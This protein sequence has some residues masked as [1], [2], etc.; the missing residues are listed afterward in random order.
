MR[1]RARRV[2]YGLEDIAYL[3]GRA[4]RSTGRGARRLWLR[5]SLENRRRIAVGL[6]VVLA[7]VGLRYA[8]VPILPCE[9]PGGDECPPEDEAAG[10]V[11][12]DPLAYAHVNLDPGTEQAEAAGELAGKLPAL[13]AQAISRL[14][15]PGVSA[16]ELDRRLLP[17][18]G[19][20]AALAVVPGAEGA[21]ERVTLL[22]AEDEDAALRYAEA[23]LG[24]RVET[25][26]RDGVELRVDAAGRAAAL[27]DGFL[28]VGEEEAVG[29]V[30]EVTEGAESLSDS[31]EAGE[32]RDELPSERLADAYVS[33]DGIA[34]LLSRDRGVLGSLDVLVNFAASRGV[35]AALVAEDDALELTVESRLDPE[36]LE[37]EPGFFGALPPF[38]PDL[39]SEASPEA[40]AYVG[41]GDPG[42]SI[43]RLLEQAAVEAPALAAGFEA[44]AR[45]VRRSGGLDLEGDV[46]PLL[47]S[48]ASFTLEPPPPEAAREDGERRG[49]GAEREAGGGL[50]E[51]VP[52]APLPPGPAAPPFLTFL[53]DD[54]E[55]EDARRALARLQVPIARAVKPEEGLQAPVYRE[56][57][58]DGVE[59]RSVRVSPAVDLTFAVFDG[60]LVVST[61]PAGVEQVKSGDDGLDSSD[62]FEAATEDF[63][64]RVSLLVYLDLAGLVELAEAAG[65]AE[66]PA[67]SLVAGDL[68]RLDLAGIAIKQDEGALAT[69]ARV[70]VD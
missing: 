64:V 28:V 33:E 37:A 10:L 23:A 44:L 41:L 8:V 62:P 67:Y 13:A 35:A 66:D 30:I 14:E 22:E 6:V 58:I 34:E 32:V 48:E 9:F 61:S 40:L 12:A 51:D 70:T 20:E 26:E 38:D 53:A 60:K 57:E 36:R 21:P 17:W 29:E 39:A 52:A 54:V 65:L 43:G 63:P 18:F 42:E 5:V 2:R 56:Q 27:T 55:E 3:L 69:S 49:G 11:P 7:L 59:T 46:L 16:A 4:L 45:D 15:A 25:T 47:G 19:G 68:R 50:P 31:G 24:E 1:S